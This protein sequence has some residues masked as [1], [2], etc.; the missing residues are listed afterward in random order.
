MIDDPRKA[1]IIPLFGL[2]SKTRASPDDPQGLPSTREPAVAAGG[3][4]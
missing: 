4:R 2:P 1:D 3:H